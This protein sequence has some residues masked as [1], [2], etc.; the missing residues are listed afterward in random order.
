MSTP[1]KKVKDKVKAL[2]AE[3]GAY[4]FM[5]ATHGYGSSGVPD[6]S[7][8]LHG[9]FIGIEC[10][11]NGGKPTALQLKNLRM[12]VAAGGI[13]VLVDETSISEL[14]ALLTSVNKLN[15]GVFL[16]FLGGNASE[17]VD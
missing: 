14:D 4:H 17:R 11:A 6:I 2:L 3:H 9:R 7:A 5:P 10:K 8:C 15:G 16:D 12:I 13:A 1:E